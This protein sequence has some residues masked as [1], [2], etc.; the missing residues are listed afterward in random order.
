LSIFDQREFACRCEWGSHACAAL[1]PADV[2]IVVDVLSFTTCVDVA[3]SRG[4][5]IWPARPGESAAA[6]PGAVVAGRRGLAEYS[7][8]PA[9]FLT[10]PAGLHCVLPSPNGAALARAAAQSGAVV[11]AACLRNAEAVAEYASTIGATFNVCPAGER[12][13]DGSLR[14]AIE[15][16]IGA[17]AVLRSLPGRKSPEAVSAIATFEHVREEIR[18]VLAGCASGRELIELGCAGDVELASEVDVSGTVPR[19]VGDVFAVAQPHGTHQ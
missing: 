11:L 15:D 10:A 7:L 4:V 5:S 1:A 12:W 18:H 8:S 13:P 2:I 9:S 14:F 16:W 3:V 6:P 17:G 19:L